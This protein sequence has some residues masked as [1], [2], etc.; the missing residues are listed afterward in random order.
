[1]S[2]HISLDLAD[3]SL[4]RVQQDK[5]NDRQ[6]KEH[7]SLLLG[8]EFLSKAV[9]TPNLWPSLTCF[10]AFSLSKLYIKW[11]AKKFHNRQCGPALYGYMKRSKIMWKESSASDFCPFSTFVP[12]ISHQV[13]FPLHKESF[14]YKRPPS[15]CSS[16][17]KVV[18]QF[19]G[20]TTFVPNLHT[21]WHTVSCQYIPGLNIWWHTKNEKYQVWVSPLD[22]QKQK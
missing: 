19:C 15:S 21:F 1:M 2:R 9:S 8:N 5:S 13:N 16:A 22:Y 14:D 18:T 4:L 11:A 17:Y 6:S 20:E 7:N 10:V 12:N 3:Q